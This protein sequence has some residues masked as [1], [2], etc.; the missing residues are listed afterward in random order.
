MW[1]QLDVL[2]SLY[3]IGRGIFNG[4]VGLIPSN[5]LIF[6]RFSEYVTPAVSADAGTEP[7]S[8]VTDDTSD[9]ESLADDDQQVK[10][11]QKREKVGFRDR[12]VI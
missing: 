11:K 2:P 7:N 3:T 8:T 5:I 4:I 10:K 9:D 1:Y 12:K 6:T